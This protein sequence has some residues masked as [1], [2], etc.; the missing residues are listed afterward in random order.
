M[1]IS[2]EI[3]C[4][5][6]LHLLL[7][8]SNRYLVEPK[9]IMTIYHA[10]FSNNVVWL[11]MAIKSVLLVLIMTF[12]CNEKVKFRRLFN[13][14]SAL[15]YIYLFKVNFLKQIKIFLK[16]FI[17]ELLE[18]GTLDPSQAVILAPFCENIKYC[19]SFCIESCYY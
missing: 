7:F 6:L 11:L 10:F 18:I 5:R 2:F 1:K 14:N 17:F 16:L 8:L 19:C 13:I 3:T 15:I 9:R 12:L 4:S